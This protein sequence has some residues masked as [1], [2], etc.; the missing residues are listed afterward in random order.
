[1]L[2]L[3]ENAYRGHSK[4]N[5]NSRAAAAESPEIP[6]NVQIYPHPSAATAAYSH[7]QRQHGIDVNKIE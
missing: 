4:G 7:L 2:T 5:N 6:E 1:L 3:P